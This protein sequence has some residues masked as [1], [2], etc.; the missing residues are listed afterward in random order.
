MEWRHKE[1][2]RKLK[3][4]HDQLEARVRCPQGDKHSA[5]TMHECTQEESHTQ[6]TINTLDDPNLLHIHIHEG[7]AT[8]RYPFVDRL[9][10]SNQFLGWKPLNLEHYDGTTDPDEHLDAF[11]TEDNLYNNS[12]AIMC[13]VFPTSPKGETLPWYRGL[14]PQFINI[15]NTLVEWF[16]C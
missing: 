11:F 5:H 10:E 15:F 8:C 16:N 14:S 9:M 4:G 13:Q 3:A 6:H 12:D 1:E 7:L 2:L